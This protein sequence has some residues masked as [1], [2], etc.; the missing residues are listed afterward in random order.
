MLSN[1]VLYG[2]LGEKINQ[3]ARLVKCKSVDALHNKDNYF[4]IPVIYWTNDNMS[5]MLMTQKEGVKVIIRGR[6]DSNDEFPLYVVCEYID[7]VK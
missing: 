4:N 6:L 5:N 3:K 1:V 2:L 7:V